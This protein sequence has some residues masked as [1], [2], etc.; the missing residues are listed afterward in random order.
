LPE[1]TEGIMN[2]FLQNVINDINNMTVDEA[3]EW[4]YKLFFR[5]R[6]TVNDAAD[7]DYM[8]T[9]IYKPERNYSFIL[10]IILC[11]M[12]VPVSVIVRNKIRLKKIEEEKTEHSQEV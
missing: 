2:S 6:A 7:E 8:P 3:T 5:E 9:I 12:A 11:M 10:L 1:G 4:I